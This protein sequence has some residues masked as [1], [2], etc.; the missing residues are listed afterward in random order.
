MNRIIQTLI[1]VF[2]TSFAVN[3][4]LSEEAVRLF[5]PNE[6]L[7]SLQTQIEN[8]TDN[9][10]FIELAE[11]MSSRYDAAKTTILYNQA[12]PTS[13][14][15]ILSTE[16][17]GDRVAAADDFVVPAGF[18]WTITDVFAE[19]FINPPALT[20]EGVT[21]E[22]RADAG[23]APGPV[24][25]SSTH[26]TTVGDAIFNAGDW[27][28]D[29]T[30]ITLQPGTYWLAF[31]G[32][33]SFAPNILAVRWNWTTTGALINSEAHLESTGSSFPVFPWMP[34]SNVIGPGSE[35]TLFALEGSEDEIVVEMA[36]P[37]PTLGEWSLMILAG[38]LLIFGLVLI[39][40]RQS[41][42]A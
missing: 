24:I 42:I 38:L 40:Q 33:D 17:P 31:L 11:K 6:K 32:A 8:N 7:A 26:T 20:P 4:Q 22:I 37:I 5:T 13:T 23:G 10:V 16:V 41:S 12:D 9:Q 1:V 18:T 27:M 29:I 19:G 30:D 35:S 2:C 34:L 15:G 39:K 36:S 3:A 14:A 25:A 21:V 28:A